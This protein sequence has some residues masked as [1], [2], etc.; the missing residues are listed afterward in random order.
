[1]RIAQ[2]ESQ[3]FAR[4]V[5]A[6]VDAGLVA[7]RVEP[8]P[9]MRRQPDRVQP[10]QAIRRGGIAGGQA[11]VAQARRDAVGPEQGRQQWLLA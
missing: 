4:R 7:A 10:V 1:M 6:G 3:R 2:A 11:L 8:I 9:A 5:E